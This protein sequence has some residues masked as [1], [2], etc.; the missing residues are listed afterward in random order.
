MSF[1]YHVK[2]IKREGMIILNLIVIL[3][4]YNGELLYRVIKIIQIRKIK[5]LINLKID[6][7]TPDAAAAAAA[8]LS[9]PTSSQRIAGEFHLE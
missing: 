5:N 8:I 2:N 6:L 4:Y 3:N 9:A 7:V 1:L